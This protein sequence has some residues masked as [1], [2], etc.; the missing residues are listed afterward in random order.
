M[1]RRSLLPL[2]LFLAG[3]AVV[4]AAGPDLALLKKNTQVF[5]SIVHEILKQNFPN[6]FALTVKP[7]GSFLEGYGIVVFFHLNINRAQIRTPFGMVPA[8]GKE[9]PKEEQLGILKDSMIRCLADHGSTFKQ[10]SDQH[11]ISISAYVED[12]NELDSASKTTVVVISTSKE[13]VDLFTTEKM[14]FEK[15]KEQ[16]SVIE[17]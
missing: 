17:Y 8:R 10:L 5:E 13:S 6:P 7:E 15:F 12:R 1:E 2:V 9:L 11:R 14:S 3:T 16:T 4:S